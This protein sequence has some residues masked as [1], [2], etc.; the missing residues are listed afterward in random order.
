MASAWKEPG[1]KTNSISVAVCLPSRVD[2]GDFC[3]RVVDEVSVLEVSV[4]W[5][6][7]LTNVLL[8]HRQWLAKE[9]IGGL[10]PYHAY[11]LGFESALMDLR[12]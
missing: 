3:F 7:A 8:M 11:I 10:E 6:A 9:R 4:T 12:K 5:T 2:R 1:S